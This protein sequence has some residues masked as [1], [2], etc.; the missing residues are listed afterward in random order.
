VLPLSHDEV[1][2]GKGSLLQKMPGDRWQQLA[3]L[4]ALYGYMWAHPGKKLLFMGGELA[5]EYEWDHDGSVEWHLRESPA[6]EGVHALVRDLNRIYRDEPA[7]WE[8]DAEPDGF[9]WIESHD[10]AANILVFIRLSRGGARMLVCATNFSPVPRPGYRVGLPR[11][12]RWLEILNTDD[13]R[14]GGTGVVVDGSVEATAGP[15]HEQPFSAQLALP[16]LA[17][18]WLTP[19]IAE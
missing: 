17:T 5:Q 11:G 8:L 6:H 15:W 2:H 13:A 1:V 12:G 4:R 19:E 14:Y 16:P 18:V 7:L 9:S 3:N 10:A